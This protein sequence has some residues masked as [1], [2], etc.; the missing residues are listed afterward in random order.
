MGF[1]ESSFRLYE[2]T[3]AYGCLQDKAFLH[4]TANTFKDTKTKEPLWTDFVAP[5]WIKQYFAAVIVLIQHSLSS[6]YADDHESETHL[7]VVAMENEWSKFMKYSTQ[8][9]FYKYASAMHD[10]Y[11]K[12]IVF[13]GDSSYLKT[14]LA[15]IDCETTTTHTIKLQ[16]VYSGIFVVDSQS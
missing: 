3:H 4:W 12:C 1:K 9:I 8:M 7:F 14:C 2:L 16:S 11:A 10:C 6:Q 15:K 5:N 13:V